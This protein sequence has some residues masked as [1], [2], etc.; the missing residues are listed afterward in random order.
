[1]SYEDGKKL[2]IFTGNANPELAK[3]IADYLGLELGKA[4]VGK[5]NNGEIQVMIDESV[6]GKDVFV[7]QPTC[8]P[9]NDTLMELLIM[10]DALKRASAKHITA[11]VP[12]Y[13]YARQDRKTR[14]REPITSKLVADLMTTSG[15]TRVVTMDLHAGQIQGFFDIPVDHLGSAS[16]IAKYI[17]QKKEETDMGD[18]VVVSPDLGGVTRARDLADRRALHFD[19]VGVALFLNRLFRLGVA[20]EGVARGDLARDGLHAAGSAGVQRGLYQR[21]VAVVLAQERCALGDHAQLGV[22]V[23]DRLADADVA[24]ADLTCHVACDTAENQ[25][26]N[27]VFCAQHLHGGRGV[28]LAHARAADD[29]LLALQR[30]AV[31]LDPG[32]VLFGHVL[33]PCAQLVDFVGHSAHNANNHGQTS[34]KR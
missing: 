16:I 30:A 24:N 34:V 6:R 17:N 10:A 12:Y 31:V 5:F 27:A 8:Q 33:Q 2:K 28:C 19:A 13:G 29:D 18:I 1:M 21:G 23:D 3:E 4:F 11:V 32:V 15:I 26:I 7:I 14:G 9:A 20:D 22:V 25:L